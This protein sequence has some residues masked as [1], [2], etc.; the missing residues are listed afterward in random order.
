MNTTRDI[1]AVIH[2]NTLVSFKSNTQQPAAP[3]PTQWVSKSARPTP[4]LP[5]A[6][7][8]ADT[9][10]LFQKMQAEPDAK[11]KL[12]LRNRIIEGNLL[13]CYKMAG[14]FRSYSVDFS[15]LVSEAQ[16]ALVDAINRWIPE[17]GEFAK[18]AS[19]HIFYRIKQYI[20]AEISYREHGVDISNRRAIRAI[21][22]IRRD[23]V[24]KN[25]TVDQVSE[26]ELA[27]IAQC[28]VLMIRALRPYLETIVPLKE[29]L[30]SH[31]ARAESMAIGR[32]I[33]EENV[34][35]LGHSHS[36][37]AFFDL[38]SVG[39]LYDRIINAL[40]P[41]ARDIY[42]EVK[43]L[44]KDEAP[45]T[46]AEVAAKHNLTAVRVFQ[47][48]SESDKYIQQRMAYILKKEG[49]RFRKS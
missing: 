12:E 20:E 21:N 39:K 44:G 48:F 22:R 49:Y 13:L 41:R 29:K 25:L 32:K 33:A 9:L 40:D 24:A 16:M 36:T 46:Y 47:I 37:L 18:F 11:A 30:F 17:K 34:E 28:S 27:K 8:Q 5:A 7:S 4:I 38:L 42:R 26:Q 14:R 19:T 1:D 43:G 23:L 35:I 3:A 31:K 6:I 45:K 10:G 2:S 15:E